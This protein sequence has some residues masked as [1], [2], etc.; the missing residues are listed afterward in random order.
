MHTSPG[1][2]GWSGNL[3]NSARVDFAKWIVD[4][5][6]TNYMINNPRLLSE[7]RPLIDS[8]KGFIQIPSPSS[9]SELSR[10]VPSPSSTDLSITGP[11]PDY[12]PAVLPSLSTPPAPS[13]PIVRRSHRFIN[14]DE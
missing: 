3:D 11:S 8:S 5:G 7:T 6:A 14:L 2:Y 10:E 12:V 1:T 9:P 13:S 4:T